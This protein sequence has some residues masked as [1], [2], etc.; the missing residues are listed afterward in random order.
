MDIAAEFADI[1]GAEPL[2]GIEDAWTWSVLGGDVRL[3]AALSLDGNHAFQVNCRT[4]FTPERA[5]RILSEARTLSATL[6]AASPFATTE[7]TLPDFTFNRMASV[8]PSV[9][10][11][12]RHTPL[13]DVTYAVFPAWH[14]EFS[15]D[16][17]KDEAYVRYKKMLSTAYYDRK[18][19][20]FLRMTRFTPEGG[21]LGNDDGRRAVASAEQLESGIAA[22]TGVDNGWVECENFLGEVRRIEWRAGHLEARNPATDTQ[23]RL[24]PNE[25]KGWIKQFLNIGEG[26]VG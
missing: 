15:G 24:E 7:F 21:T 5:I 17:T 25:V 22:I 14:C 20:P 26:D 13:N 2:P 19:V 12:H 6:L 9:A 10:N 23:Q 3:A 18:P 16:E 11:L 4:N 1:A 8:L